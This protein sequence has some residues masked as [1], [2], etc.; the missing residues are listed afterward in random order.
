VHNKEAFTTIRRPSPKGEAF[1]IER[2]HIRGTNTT[3]ER[4]WE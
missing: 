4:S 2:D 3:E 1:P